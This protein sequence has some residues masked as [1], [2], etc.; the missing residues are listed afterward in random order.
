MTK[1]SV[2][3]RIAL[4]RADAVR[5][6]SRNGSRVLGRKGFPCDTVL[7]P[8]DMICVLLFAPLSDIDG[9]VF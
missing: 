7:H 8:L 6:V 9:G 2:C 3:G 5:E 4:F 1:Y